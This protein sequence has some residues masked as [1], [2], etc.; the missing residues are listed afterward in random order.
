MATPMDTTLKSYL[1][2]D[3]NLQNIIPGAWF[4]KKKSDCRSYGIGFLTAPA[5]G[6]GTDGRSC[7]DLIS[8]S[9]AVLVLFPSTSLLYFTK[10]VGLAVIQVCIAMNGFTQSEPCTDRFNPRNVKRGW[11]KL[12][13]QRADRLTQ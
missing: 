9:V 11:E 7:C 10:A 3:I 5:G 13:G 6:D 1:T 8:P 12:Q 2:P 4:E